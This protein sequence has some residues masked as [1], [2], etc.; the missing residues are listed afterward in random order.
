MSDDD[1]L[2]SALIDL[3]H[4]VAFPPTPQL[5]AGV[6]IAIQAEP[7]GHRSGW[8]LA[9]LPRP[10]WRSF[11]LVGAALIVL[12]GVAGAV[13]LGTGAI[14]IRFGEPSPL[15]TAVTSQRGF[16]TEVTLEQARGLAGFEI[17]LPVTDLPP[18][19]HVLFAS[20]PAGGTVT[21]AWDDLPGY[22]AGSDGIG[23]AV[24]EF[25][26]DI[27]S[28]S[29]T[30][31]LLEGTAVETVLLDGTTAWWV[32]GGEH[33]FFYTDAN[34]DVVDSTVRLVG[35]VLFWE[36]GGVTFRI[37]GAPSLDAALVVAR[38]LASD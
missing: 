23:L 32:E 8:R 21:L 16:G 11:V 25:R 13:G 17:R 12:A 29:F 24:M 4:A 31:M 35:N 14:H 37:E 2:E 38:S 27:D 20:R 36:R 1:R 34:G 30:K 26:A 6:L 3:G 19:D 9:A 7:G 18:P 28:G 5:A 10:V 22:P 15:P 33:Y